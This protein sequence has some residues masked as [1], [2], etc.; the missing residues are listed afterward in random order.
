MKRYLYKN[1]SRVK[2]C[3]MLAKKNMPLSEEINTPYV[4]KCKIFFYVRNSQ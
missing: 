2:K 3:A 1:R 4:W